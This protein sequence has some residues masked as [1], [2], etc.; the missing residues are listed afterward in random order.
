MSFVCSRRI[1]GGGARRWREAW[2]CFQ[3][4]FCACATRPKQRAFVE[5]AATSPCSSES[6][7]RII[8]HQLKRGAL[9]QQDVHRSSRCSSSKARERAVSA[10]A[11][12]A[13][14]TERPRRQRRRVSTRHQSIQAARHF[15]SI[16]RRA[17]LS[18]LYGGAAAQGARPGPGRVPGRAA[19]G[20]PRPSLVSREVDRRI[21]SVAMRNWYTTLLPRWPQGRHSR[22]AAAPTPA[23]YQRRSCRALSSVL[24]L[25]WQIACREKFRCQVTFPDGVRLAHTGT[26]GSAATDRML[27][28]LAASTAA[29][30][31]RDHDVAEIDPADR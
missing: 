27:M 19:R 18:A 3:I 15:K 29:I 8:Q 25:C 17:T 2:W 11:G 30:G 21:G 10:A 26:F 28:P 24:S 4:G 20:D 12:L 6:T 31:E 7:A 22:I 1:R 16:P 23:W 14:G 5:R 9:L 13:V